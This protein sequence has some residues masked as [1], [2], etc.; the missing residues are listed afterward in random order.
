MYHPAKANFLENRNSTMRHF[1]LLYTLAFLHQSTTSLCKLRT[2]QQ[3]LCNFF[4]RR[5]T[6]F[7][8]SLKT[9]FLEIPPWPSFAYVKFMS[10]SRWWTIKSRVTYLRSLTV[11]IFLCWLDTYSVIVV[12]TQSRTG[13]L[14]RHCDYGPGR[15]V[16]L[17]KR[18]NR[19][20]IPF[21]ETKNNKKSVVSRLSLQG[22]CFTIW[23]K[24]IPMSTL[25]PD[26]FY[27]GTPEETFP[28]PVADDVV[29]R[30]VL[31]PRSTPGD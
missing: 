6:L 2:Y 22:I 21:E 9:R 8:P 26:E 1:L 27:V 24:L 31:R 16:V 12:V 18:H 28:G 11:S 30:S 3:I 14:L 23:Y 29:S 13:P 10:N 15:H 19:T 5:K 20:R 7:L 17:R 25:A 4:P